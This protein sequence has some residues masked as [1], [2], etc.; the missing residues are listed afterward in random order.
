MNIALFFGSFNPFHNGH[1]NL[2]R[3]LTENKLFDE[4]WYV[5]SPLNPLKENVTEII[6][7]KLRYDMISGAIVDFP[8]LKV[9]DVEFNMPKPS[10]TYQTLEKLRTNYPKLKFSIVIGSDN[11]LIFDKWVNYKTILRDFDVCVYPRHGFNFHDVSKLYPTMVLLNSVCYDISSTQI[12][13]SIKELKD[14][15]ELTHP[16]VCQY[17]YS[18]KLY[19]T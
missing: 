13:T 15:S 10:Y 9:S 18:N 14:V 19:L 4:V 16:F 8:E 1:L 11:A 3:Y 17:I 2:G 5:V 6:D 7:E 12:R